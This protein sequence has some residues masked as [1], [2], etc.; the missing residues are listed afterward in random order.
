MNWLT[1]QLYLHL[2]VPCLLASV[3]P[4][5]VRRSGKRSNN[6]DGIPLDDLLF[7]SSSRKK[8]SKDITLSSGICSVHSSF[9]SSFNASNNL[10]KADDFG[11]TSS[12]TVASTN[13]SFKI[14]ATKKSRKRSLKH[15]RLVLNELNKRN[16]GHEDDLLENIK[17]TPLKRIFDLDNESEASWNIAT[18]KCGFQ[19]S[20]FLPKR[21]P[22]FKDCF[23]PTELRISR[24][25]AEEYMHRNKNKKPLLTSP[26]DLPQRK[27]P[28]DK[29]DALAIISKLSQEQKNIERSLRDEFLSDEEQED[30]YNSEE[31][32]LILNNS[33]TF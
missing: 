15:R 30:G 16:A 33:V 21:T 4:T 12:S 7:V 2:T 24:K 8:K 3:L 17:L 6:V 31:G 14:P 28:A 32:E 10:S 5:P 20:P 26:K 27:R 25:R 18:P 11:F 22:V 13:S 9:V 29:S 19:L 23:S 1:T